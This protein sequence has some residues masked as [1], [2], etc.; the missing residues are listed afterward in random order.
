MAAR[1][2]SI[3]KKP[4]F[5]EDHRAEREILDNP[6]PPSR[7]MHHDFPC[8]LTTVVIFQGFYSQ[9]TEWSQK[10]SAYRYVF[11]SSVMSKHGIHVSGCSEAAMVLEATKLELKNNTILLKDA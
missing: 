5:Y 8:S 6:L 7:S 11:G 1:C 4:D 10:M 3:G 9:V 2:L